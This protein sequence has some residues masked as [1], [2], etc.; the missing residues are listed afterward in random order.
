MNWNIKVKRGDHRLHASF[1]GFL[2][3]DGIQEFG[4]D[5]YRQPFLQPHTVNWETIV[6]SDILEE[7]EASD[8]EA[9]VSGE[10]VGQSPPVTGML[11]E[12]HRPRREHRRHRESTHSDGAAVLHSTQSLPQADENMMSH[13]RFRRKSR[14][15]RRRPSREFHNSKLAQGRALRYTSSESFG[16][17][18][19]VITSGYWRRR[20]IE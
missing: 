9:L 11:P 17:G 4:F 6:E 19:G 3:T 7:A 15:L 18:N 2:L 13:Q 20:R 10:S 5:Q 12:L 1:T 8:A 14:A 16:Y